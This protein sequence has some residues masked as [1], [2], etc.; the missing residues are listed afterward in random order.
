MKKRNIILIFA[1]I[2]AAALL[3]WF[4]T[5]KTDSRTVAIPAADIGAAES[6]GDAEAVADAEGGADG[7]SEA[8]KAAAAAYFEQC[9]AET[10]LLLTTNSGMYS[11]I[12]LNEENEF[13]VTQADGSRNTVHIGVNS[14][15]M[16]ESNCDNQNC[17]GEGEVTLEN[18][19]TRILRNMVICLPHGISLEMLTPEEAEAV[20]LDMLAQEELYAAAMAESADEAE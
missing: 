18:M 9:P 6:A 4:G 12:P 10:Y 11:P 8:V 5:R 3:F 19:N 20:L 2:A 15:Y 17:V 13:T 1:I 14:F 16:K 7:Y